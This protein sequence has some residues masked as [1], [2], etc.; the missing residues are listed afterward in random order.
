MELIGYYLLFALSIAISAC[1]FWFWPVLREARLSGVQNSFTE[2][3]K[4]STVVY[5]LVSS[6][7]AP[8]LIPPMFSEEMARR[9]ETGLRKEI[10]KTDKEIDT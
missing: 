2:Y 10:L 8:L 5:V 9:F 6:L 3:P 1:Y 4:L 7:V